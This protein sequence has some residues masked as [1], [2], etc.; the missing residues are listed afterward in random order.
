MISRLQR[1]IL[2]FVK[3]S[4]EHKGYRY[5]EA[6]SELFNTL[7]AKYPESSAKI[8]IALKLLDE[9]G[10]LEVTYNNVKAPTALRITNKGGQELEPWCIK[11][12]RFF[13][14]SITIIISICALIVSISSC[15][16]SNNANIIAT[17]IN[18]REVEAQSQKV[19]GDIFD[20]IYGDK[21][22]V[23]IINKLRPE[24]SYTNTDHFIDTLEDLNIAFCSQIVT[25]MHIQAV[26]QKTLNIICTNKPLSDRYGED[27][28]GVAILCNEFVPGSYFA[29]HINKAKLD[30]CKS[31]QP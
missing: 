23:E 3:R 30:T 11:L 9:A 7:L 4:N 6:A 24:R 27:K 22:N 15:S 25:R 1:E 17:G 20:R 13:T 16:N 10:K 26:M 28:N 12:A 18:T 14:G 8:H 19:I 2:E 21:D 29:S 5:L 31:L